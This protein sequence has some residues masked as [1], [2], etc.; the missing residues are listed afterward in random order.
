MPR[1]S[2]PTTYDLRT[3]FGGNVS[4]SWNTSLCN[5][6]LLSVISFGLGP[7]IFLS[8]P[9]SNTSAS[10]PTITRETKFYNRRKQEK[11]FYKADRKTQHSGPNGSRHSPNPLDLHSS[12]IQFW[13]VRAVPKFLNWSTLTK[14]LPTFV[15]WLCPTYWY[16]DMII[17]ATSFSLQLHLGQFPYYRSVSL[18]CFSS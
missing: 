16:R 9:F 15:L 14:D 6:L 11:S 7:N 18:L 17:Q 5:F 2:H 8:A 3:I 1:P 10:V 4:N 13:F 12:C